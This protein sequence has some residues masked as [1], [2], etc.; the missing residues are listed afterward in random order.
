MAKTQKRSGKRALARA[1]VAK[2]TMHGVPHD[3]VKTDIGVTIV[4]VAS[5]SS[6]EWV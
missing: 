4:S 3:V 1:L 6:P 2:V 5:G